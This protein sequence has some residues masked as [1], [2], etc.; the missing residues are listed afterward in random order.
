MSANPTNYSG[1]GNNGHDPITGSLTRRLGP[2]GKYHSVVT[3]TNITQ[4]FNSESAN[5]AYGAFMLGDGANIA[6][7][8]IDLEGGGTLFGTDLLEHHIYEFAPSLVKAKTKSIY[9]FKV[10][11]TGY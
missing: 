6:G 7:T 5:Y 3:V 8:S 9:V 1:W 2:P 10:R 11:N 4:S